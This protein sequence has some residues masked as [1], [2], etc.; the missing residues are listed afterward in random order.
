VSEYGFSDVV[1]PGGVSFSMKIAPEDSMNEAVQVPTGDNTIGQPVVTCHGRVLMMLSC[2]NNTNCDSQLSAAKDRL[3]PHVITIRGEIMS[4]DD[5]ECQ[6]VGEYDGKSIHMEYD[7][8]DSFK[9]CDDARE[10]DQMVVKAPA[11]DVLDRSTKPTLIGIKGWAASVVTH[12]LTALT[13]LS[14]LEEVT[15]KDAQEIPLPIQM[16]LGGKA[17]GT[18]PIGSA[19]P[20]SQPADDQ[21]IDRQ[22]RSQAVVSSGNVS[23]ARLSKG[24]TKEGVAN[25]PNVSHA[26]GHP[27]AMESRSDSTG[28]DHK[29]LASPVTEMAGDVSATL[30]MEKAA[31]RTLAAAERLIPSNGNPATHRADV[32]ALSGTERSGRHADGRGRQQ[33]RNRVDSGSQWESDSDVSCLNGRS[34]RCETIPLQ[35]PR[36]ARQF[37]SIRQKTD[38]QVRDAI[39]LKVSA[40]V[41]V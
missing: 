28:F 8:D 38:R 12:V 34:S 27:P 4:D 20:S 6:G 3:E 32:V 22:A 11:G 19:R 39:G 2:G 5:G 26:D 7:G 35:C 41:L 18:T 33:V 23:L 9:D 15:G 40:G 25:P 36:W 21:R 10:C 17:H 31:A 24:G 1:N 13:T 37:R 14:E 16:Q 29:H 30:G